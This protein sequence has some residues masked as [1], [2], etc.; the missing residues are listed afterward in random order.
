MDAQEQDYTALLERDY[1]QDPMAQSLIQ[2]LREDLK[3]TDKEIWELL[4][5]FY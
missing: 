4:E 3:R 2:E 5:S 1:G